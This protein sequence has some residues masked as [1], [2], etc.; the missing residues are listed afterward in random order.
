MIYYTILCVVAGGLPWSVTKYCFSMEKI[1]SVLL[2]FFSSSFMFILT[3]GLQRMQHISRFY[4]VILGWNGMPQINTQNIRKLCLITYKLVK[5]KNMVQTH[6]TRIIYYP[7]YRSNFQYRILVHEWPRDNILNALI[8][9]QNNIFRVFLNKY[10][11]KR[12]TNEN[13][14]EFGVLPVRYIY[15]KKIAIMHLLKF[16]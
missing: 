7:L 5:I 15:K 6:T 11:I 14:R 1:K 12:S 8:I 10:T 9:N 3:S 2:H 4:G 13:Y 16:F